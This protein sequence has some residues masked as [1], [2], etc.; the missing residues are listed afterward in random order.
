MTTTLQVVTTVTQT[1]N[2]MTIALPTGMY[3]IQATIPVALG[4]N[5]NGMTIGMMFPAV[6]RCELQ[7]VSTQLGAAIA[8]AATNIDLGAVAAGSTALA[9]ITSGT[10]AV[11]A[12]E[13][14]GYFAMTSTGTLLF[15]GLAEVANTAGKIMNGANIVA[16]N[17]SN[18][19]F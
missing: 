16:W 3:R 11:R 19:A 2:A 7:I 13:I 6:W 12:L 17:I 10:V 4:G 5:S 15:Y 14:D 18:G 9:V 1:F 8:I